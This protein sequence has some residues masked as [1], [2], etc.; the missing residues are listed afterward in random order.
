[1]R[2]KNMDENTINEP[3]NEEANVQDGSSEKKIK[4]S[5]IFFSIVP[6]AI[7][8]AIQT[9]AQIPFYIM[10]AVNVINEGYSANDIYEFLVALEQDLKDNYLNF[11]YAIY[12]VAGIIVFGIWYYKGFY[13]KRPKR[14]LGDFIGIKSLSAAVFMTVALYFAVQAAAI[15]INW[16]SPQIIEDYNALIEMSGLVD[17]FFVLFVY[18]IFMAPIL[19]ELCFRG[20]VFGILEDSGIRPGLIILISSLLFGAMHIAIPLQML[21]A[22]FLSLFFGYMRYKYR[23]VGFTIFIHMMFNIL[24]TFLSEAIDKSGMSEG[25]MLIFGGI[26]LFIIVFVFV[27]VNGDKKAY[28]PEAKS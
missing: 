2:A 26:A 22:M 27:L 28:K 17:N 11:V 23:S 20:V 9:V 10:S 16:I 25:L 13:K 18:T 4:K 14:K 6:A 8:V 15:V 24:G 1:M 7:M 12:A 3:Q 19:E 5:L 21:Y